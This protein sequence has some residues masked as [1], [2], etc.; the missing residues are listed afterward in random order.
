MYEAFYG[1][2][3]RPFNLTPDP[4]FLYLSEKHKEAFAHLLYGIKNRSGFV[5]VTG[6]IGTGKT[7]ICRN[8]LNQLDENTEV[9]FIFNPSLN[10]VELLERIHSEFGIESNAQNALGLVDELNS[11]LLE[12]AAEGKNCVLVIDEAQNLSP[13]VLE[14]IRLLSNLETER[15]KLLQIILIGQPELGE[16]LQLH[17]L[18]QLNQRITARYH[19]KPLSQRE[20]LQYIAY[21]LHVAGAKRRVKFDKGAIRAIYWYSGGTPRVINALCD[22]ALLIGYTRENYEITRGLIRQAAKEIR[23]ERHRSKK[24]SAAPFFGM[25]RLVPSS[26]VVFAVIMTLAL[27]V[28]FAQPLERFTREFSAFNNIVGHGMPPDAPAR[29]M[30]A[31]L[32]P[33][34]ASTAIAEAATAPA[35]PV[36][37][38]LLRLAEESRKRPADE[39]PAEETTLEPIDPALARAAAIAAMFKAWNKSSDGQLPVDD[40]VAALRAFL[41]DHDLSHEL[42][43]APVDAI[44]RINL[45]FFA[46][47]KVGDRARW[48]AVLAMEGNAVRISAQGDEEIKLPREAFEAAYAGEAVV[49]WVD[50]APDARV[51]KAEMSS[52]EVAEFR[53]QLH[54]LGRLA[55]AAG[56]RYDADTQAAVRNIQQETGLHVDGV[57]GRQVR[58]VIAS[59]LNEE[60]PHLEARPLPSA[61]LGP[62]ASQAVARDVP[63]AE[64]PV[65]AQRQ[66]AIAPPDAPPVEPKVVPEVTEIPP[67]EQ[68]APPAEADRPEPE[69]SLAPESPVAPEIE[70]NSVSTPETPD[71]PLFWLGAGAADANV[72]QAA[73]AAMAEMQQGPARQSD[74]AS[75]LPPPTPPA[76][77]RKRSTDPV[78]SGVPIVPSEPDET[79]N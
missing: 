41:K 32:P 2:R 14:Q 22:R 29:G 53:A 10:V 57:A 44:F 73:E 78:L 13:Q 46:R 70:V 6:E 47:I 17:E 49:P 50:N 7:T 62:E 76:E 26:T 51:L 18:R 37:A 1:L 52:D 59:W 54:R 60:M 20:T 66:V 28:F 39:A 5:M 72:T 63:K 27:A 3:E 12:K 31:A 8:L 21:R 79:P 67:V 69:V 58:M 56:K 55:D 35:G 40:S 19:L 16:M 43:T 75:V 24:P 23:G 38:A 74:A 33:E 64:P 4:R 71:P 36:S 45:P 42:I 61:P 9:A 68:P 30:S 15:D 65:P 11:Y 77:G 25:G 48:A 34:A